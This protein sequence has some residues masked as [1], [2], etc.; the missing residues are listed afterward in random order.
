MRANALHVT[1]SYFTLE[2][3][4]EKSGKVTCKCTKEQKKAGKEAKKMYQVE[5]KEVINNGKS[6]HMRP[7]SRHRLFF[8]YE[9]DARFYYTASWR[10]GLQ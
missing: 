10:R 5:S 3:S 4:P 2:Q 6:W 9:K 7:A 8:P 1:W